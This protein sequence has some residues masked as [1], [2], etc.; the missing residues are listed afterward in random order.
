M[1]LLGMVLFLIG[2]GIGLR[3]ADFDHSF[4]WLPLLDHRSLLTHG[5]LVPLLVCWGLE[6][7]KKEAGPA[8]RLFALGLCLASSVHLGFDLASPSRWHG[9]A[10]VHA[11]FVGR[12]DAGT[13]Q[14]WLGMGI[15]GCLYLACRT[16]RGQ[17]DLALAIIGMVLGYGVHAAAQPRAS[18]WALLALAAGC[19]AAITLFSLPNRS[20]RALWTRK[21]A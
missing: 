21:P 17:K 4:R 15:L 7:F 20:F 13:S 10:L 18:F 8:P 12:L 19:L 1:Y 11:P 6:V 2:G 14:L 3:F 5:F 9:Y 16:L